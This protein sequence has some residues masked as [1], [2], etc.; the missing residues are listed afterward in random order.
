M[1]EQYCLDLCLWDILPMPVALKSFWNCSPHQN[2]TGSGKYSFS[3][4]ILKY[5]KSSSNENA[6]CLAQAWNTKKIP[7][8]ALENE[9]HDEVK[10]S[11]R[12]GIKAEDS[13]EEP[14]IVRISLDPNDHLDKE[15]QA[16]DILSCQSNEFDDSDQIQ[17]YVSFKRTW[18]R[19][20]V[21][22]KTI[23]RSMRRFYY[24]ETKYIFKKIK[25]QDSNKLSFHHVFQKAK[26]G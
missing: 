13:E 1:F 24:R 10:S 18:T 12:S 22:L 3:N 19:K 17:S 6:F 21:M 2:V 23:A 26:E 15:F 9:M 8:Q 7:I 14:I 20:D 5:A 11:T 16:E 4:D 25:N